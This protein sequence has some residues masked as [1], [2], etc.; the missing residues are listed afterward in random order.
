MIRQWIALT[1]ASGLALMSA[2]AFAA[3]EEI[4]FFVSVDIPTLNFYV[5]PSEPDWIHREQ[6]LPW[7]VNTSTL[8]GLR[9]DFD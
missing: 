9:R 6:R 2:W 7:N 1:S 8:G 3:R 5:I 4:E